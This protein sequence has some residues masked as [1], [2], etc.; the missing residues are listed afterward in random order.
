MLG[1]IRQRSLAMG[2]QH[3]V[4]EPQGIVQYIARTGQCHVELPHRFFQASLIVQG[5]KLPVML[6]ENR[7]LRVQ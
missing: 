4:Q 3:V 2:F 1:G 6:V 7:V 5:L